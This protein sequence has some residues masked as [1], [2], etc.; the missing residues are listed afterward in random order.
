MRAMRCADSSAAKTNKTVPR[1]YDDKFVPGGLPSTRLL[2]A[3]FAC[4][5]TAMRSLPLVSRVVFAVSRLARGTG[6][7][8]WCFRRRCV[9]VIGCA[10]GVG[11]SRGAEWVWDSDGS[12]RRVC[13][14]WVK[15]VVFHG[16]FV[17]HCSQ[18]YLPIS[19]PVPAPNPNAVPKAVV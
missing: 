4:G 18:M 2:A 14:E 19:M 17:L 3:D 11:C 9:I 7:L 1:R 5:S 8:L 13:N 10:W 16:L 6:V 15:A 12:G